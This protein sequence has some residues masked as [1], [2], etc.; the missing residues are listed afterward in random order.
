MN[1]KGLLFLA[2]LLA[3]TLLIS[4]AEKSDK[5]DGN[6]SVL[7]FSNINYIYFF[8]TNLII[9]FFRNTKLVKY[10]YI[11]FLVISYFELVYH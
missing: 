6:K 4:A 11:P 8:L 3:S 2:M 1:S 9:Y 5:K 10:S 7:N